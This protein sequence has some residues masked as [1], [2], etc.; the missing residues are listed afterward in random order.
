MKNKKGILL[1]PGQ[2]ETEN[3]KLDAYIPAKVTEPWPEPI[4]TGGNAQK[5]F[6][7]ACLFRLGS[8]TGRLY[9]ETAN[10]RRFR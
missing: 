7:I 5:T 3:I 2:Q 10:F 6:T 1:S 8:I 4:G 9:S